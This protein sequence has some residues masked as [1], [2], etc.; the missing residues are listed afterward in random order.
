MPAEGTPPEGTPTP[1][2]TPAPVENNLP[3]TQEELNKIIEGRLAKLKATIVPLQTTVEEF[4]KNKSV[5]EQQQSALQEQIESMQRTLMSKEELAAKDKKEL[6]D[7]LQN[8]LKQSQQ[9][10]DKWK[11]LFER[12]NT[13]HDILSAVSVGD[14]KAVNPLQFVALLGKDTKIVEEVKEGKSTGRF[15][16]M[17]KFQGQDKDGNTVMM[18]L[19]TAEAIKEMRKLP[20]LYGNLFESGLTGGLGGTN[21]AGNDSTDLNQIGDFD[22]YKKVRDKVLA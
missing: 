22:T 19:P 10:A 9:D 1:E 4:K 8:A 20:K 14:T 12:T 15:V 13:E 11:S 3:K 2:G 17:T 7:K 5:T 18:E 6:E 21:A 16:S